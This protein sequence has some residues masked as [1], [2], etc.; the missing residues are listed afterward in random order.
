[1]KGA[2]KGGKANQPDVPIVYDSC[3]V[4]VN[5][6]IGNHQVNFT[7][8]VQANEDPEKPF[9]GDV[10]IIFPHNLPKNT[11]PPKIEISKPATDWKNTFPVLIDDNFLN[12][13]KE[14]RF[15]YK[16]VFLYKATS[17]GKAPAKKAPARGADK[18]APAAITNH[19]FF[20]D[21]SCLLIRGG[22]FKPFLSYTASCQPPGFENFTFT[23]SIDHSILSDA[24]IRRFQPF[25]CYFKGVHQL[26]NT[27]ISYEELASSCVGP[28][29]I[30]RAGPQTFTTFPQ[31]HGPEM[32]MNIA[33]VFWAPQFNEITVELR[34]RESDPPDMTNTIGSSFVL[35]I[36][37]AKKQSVVEP[38]SIDQILGAKKEN[39][40]RPY[41]ST[42]F[43][44]EK[45][46]KLLPFKPV[47]TRDSLM[48][49]GFYVENGTYITVEMENMKDHVPNMPVPVAPS[50]P[51]SQKRG[52]GAASSTAHG[53]SQAIQQVEVKAPPCFFNRVVI[54]CNLTDMPE[55]EKILVNS[56]QERIVLSNSVSFQMKDIAA[57]PTMKITKEDSDAL[58][59]FYLMAGDLHIIVLEILENS[60]TSTAFQEFLKTVLTNTQNISYL[61]DFS[62]N[63]QSPRLYGSFDCAVKKFRL[64]DPLDKLLLDPDIYVQNSHMSNCFTVLNQ[65]NGL[66]EA[67]RFSDLSVIKLWPKSQ[68]LEML[69]AKKGI[70]LSMEELSFP[71]KQPKSRVSTNSQNLDDKQNTEQEELPQLKYI[72][73]NHDL[74]E[75]PPH[76]VDYFVKKNMDYITQLENKHKHIKGLV[77]TTEDGEVEIW[78]ASKGGP[79]P[80]DPNWSTEKPE[81]HVELARAVGLD[82]FTKNLRKEDGTE[83]R[84]GT[85]F[86]CYKSAVSFLPPIEKLKANVN[87]EP[88]DNGDKSLASADSRWIKETRGPIYTSYN[89]CAHPS[90]STFTPFKPLSIEEEYK[91]AKSWVDDRVYETKPVKH[92]GR[93]NP[94]LPQFK[95]DQNILLGA[96]DPTPLT[97]QEEYH[98]PLL[99]RDNQP[100]LKPGQKRFRVVF[101]DCPPKKG[102][103]D[104]LAVKKVT[105]TF[106]PVKPGF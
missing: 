47:T 80:D 5:D 26:P 20:V 48:Q 104:S 16:I 15:V 58:S 100:E 98:D 13:I 56:I 79:S 90:D 78:D 30:V 73:I 91:P 40:A 8:S 6:P 31:K 46:R 86:Y 53:K 105:F 103:T 62:V 4:D 27:P 14:K 89:P 22:R 60:E 97:V 12:Q 84:N 63:F 102:S 88:W 95:K 11:K 82:Y 17:H 96:P 57:V 66:S 81:S 76:N 54:V 70:L 38:L 9:E 64:C 41:G 52:A 37:P 35:P 85:K 93:F 29:I 45:A 42:T 2:R 24:Q 50:T 83:I 18:S 39:T 43:S 59:G 92:L 94:V 68:D 19:T 75:S 28:H 3:G 34:D 69:N 74:I 71:P 72:P 23:V 33:V 49:P 55:H 65:L 106:P 67:K 51:T 99:N 10:D 101:P 1:M 44:L 36:D 87:N 21:V 7:F 61:A 32:K 25:V 77:E